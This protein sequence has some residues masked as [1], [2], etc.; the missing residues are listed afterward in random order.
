VNEE[1]ELAL[2]PRLASACKEWWDKSF[3]KHRV[4]GFSLGNGRFL[5]QTL[6]RLSRVGSRYRKEE[7]AFLASKYEQTSYFL[8]CLWA[9]ARLL[10]R[11]KMRPTEGPQFFIF[12][13]CTV[14]V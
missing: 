9:I 5:Q 14:Q 11:E 4:L 13:S 12:G 8:S 7:M 1:V 6:Q 10:I 2:L 3:G